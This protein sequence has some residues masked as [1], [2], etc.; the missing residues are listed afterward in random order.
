MVRKAVLL[1]CITAFDCQN[2]LDTHDAGETLQPTSTPHGTSP[3]LYVQDLTNAVEDFTGSMIIMFDRE[4]FTEDALLESSD[5]VIAAMRAMREQLV[6][7]DP[8]LA[9]LPP[10]R[11]AKEVLLTTA[12]LL[13]PV[14]EPGLLARRH[15]GALGS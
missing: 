5:G 4:R 1:H 10:D 7:Y 2:S 9:A 12:K 14:F 15:R 11:V 6:A 8:T 3:E 13:A